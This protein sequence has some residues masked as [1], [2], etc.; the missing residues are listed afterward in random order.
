MLLN[1]YHQVPRIG[2][3]FG[4]L[5]L[6]PFAAG[7]AV[8][9]A[10]TEASRGVAQGGLL[11]YGGFILCFLGGARWG[12]EIGRKPVRNDVIVGSMAGSIVSTA[13]IAATMIAPAARLVILAAA[14]IAQ[15]AWDVRSLDTPIWYSKLRHVLTAGAVLSLL[16]GSA[17]SFVG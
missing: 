5:G 15:W 8:C 6:V 3:A 13:L 9:W 17:A 1:R 12:L 11:V 14:H 4:V 10:V 7:A 16:A 2:W